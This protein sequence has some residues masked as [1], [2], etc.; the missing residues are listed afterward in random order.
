[1]II[2]KIYRKQ[3]EYLSHK[4]ELLGTLA[5]IFNKPSSYRPFEVE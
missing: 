5:S 2:F 4:N 3:K 1:M